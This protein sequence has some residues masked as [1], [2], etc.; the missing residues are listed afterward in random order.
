MCNQAM[1]NQI[2]KWNQSIHLA[3][4]DREPWFMQY[5]YESI[6]QMKPGHAKPDPKSNL[7]LGVAWKIK[8]T[9]NFQIY[10]T[11]GYR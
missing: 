8:P 7:I 2:M 10:T 9:S 6:T 5:D 3:V 4:E 1:L 11:I